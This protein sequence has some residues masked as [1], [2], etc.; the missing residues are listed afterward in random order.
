M[1]IST[2]QLEPGMVVNR[3]V[4]VNEVMLVKAHTRVAKPHIRSLRR[5][6]VSRVSIDQPTH[7]GHLLDLAKQDEER[8]RFS[9]QIFMKEKMRIEK[10]FQKVERDAQMNMIKESVLTHLERY[11]RGA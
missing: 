11:Y 10:L 2:E 6:N 5:W 8:R 4:K 1:W 7:A 3:E 9:D